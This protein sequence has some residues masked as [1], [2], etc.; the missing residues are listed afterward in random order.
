[1]YIVFADR[2]LINHVVLFKRQ[3]LLREHLVHAIAI[4]IVL[5]IIKWACGDKHNAPAL[6]KFLAKSLR[7]LIRK[8]MIRETAIYC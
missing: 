3:S 1:M 6:R 5:F 8:V 4:V 2:A 7:N